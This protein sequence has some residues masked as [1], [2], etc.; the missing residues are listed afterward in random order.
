MQ[1]NLDVVLGRRKD[2]GGSINIRKSK[3]LAEEIDFLGHNIG[4][5]RIQAMDKDITAIGHYKKPSTSK[6]M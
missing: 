4:R 2:K 5:N 3:F 1:A 6:E